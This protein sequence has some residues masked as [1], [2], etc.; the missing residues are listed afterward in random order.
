MLS[1]LGIVTFVNRN[2]LTAGSSLYRATEASGEPQPSNSWFVRA[3]WASNVNVAVEM[4]RLIRR[5]K[6][7]D[8]K[9]G[10]SVWDE[11]AAT[12]NNLRT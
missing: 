4:T 5:R 8:G 7:R 1:R 3:A 6:R 2:G 12:T 10:G 11:M 9:P